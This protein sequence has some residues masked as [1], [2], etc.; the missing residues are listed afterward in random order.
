MA[1][2]SLRLKGLPLNL[3]P[4][5]INFFSGP[6]STPPNYFGLKFLGPLPKIK[7]GC[8]H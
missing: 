8:Y 7:M 2:A 4:P 6:P 1:M 5:K 3:A